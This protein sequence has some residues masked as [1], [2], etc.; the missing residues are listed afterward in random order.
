MAADCRPERWIY[1]MVNG[2][3]LSIGFCFE[4]GGYGVNLADD[5]L[6]G[7]RGFWWQDVWK[8]GVLR[9]TFIERMW[10]S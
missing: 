5:A 8:K 4:R 7:M 3:R 10:W 1:W 2:E 6:A 9:P